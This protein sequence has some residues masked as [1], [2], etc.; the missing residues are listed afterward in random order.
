MISYCA[1]GC[2]LEFQTMLPKE[3]S[4]SLHGKFIFHFPSAQNEFFCEGP[5]IYL[6]KNCTKLFL[7]NTRTYLMHN[8][9][10]GWLSKALI[11]L[12]W[13]R[14]ISANL[15]GSG[16]NCNCSYLIVCSLFFPKIISRYINIYLIRETS[17]VF[18]DS[19]TR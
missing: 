13:K 16:S 9:Q 10:N 15:V 8:W 4:F 12:W 1:H 17:K 14:Q 18:K 11:H 19:I 5:T 7:Q 3:F 2:I 6:L